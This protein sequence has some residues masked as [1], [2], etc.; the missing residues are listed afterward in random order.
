M[1]IALPSLQVGLPILIM[2]AGFVLLAVL[3]LFAVRHWQRRHPHRPRRELTYSQALS[4]RL[5]KTA[6]CRTQP[7]LKRGADGDMAAQPRISTAGLNS[8]AMRW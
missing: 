7:T 6:A 4:S 8:D 5:G 2:W 1:R 3:G